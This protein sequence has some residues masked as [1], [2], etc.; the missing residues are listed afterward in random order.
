MGHLP[1]S[2]TFGTRSVRGKP[3]FPP[4]Q[5][6]NPH[7]IALPAP[8][9]KGKIG[10]VIQARTIGS[11]LP[12]WAGVGF[13][14][15][16][17]I[18]ATASDFPLLKCSATGWTVED[19]LPGNTLSA[20]AATRDGY[21]WAAGL[22]GIARFDGVRFVR[23]RLGDGL[24]SLQIQH[25]L[26]DRTGRL[27]IGTE[28]GG[29][30]LREGGYFRA[31][32]K[33]NGLGGNSVRGIAEDAEGG[34][35]VAHE[36][37]LSRWTEG[38]F[39]EMPLPQQNSKRTGC[40]SVFCGAT[41]VW[42]VSNDWIGREWRNGNWQTVPALQKTGFRFQRIFQTR[43]GVLWSQLYPYGLA[44][45]EGDQWRLF[46]TESG[47]PKSYVSSVLEQSEGVFLCGTFDEGLFLF[48]D[49][50]AKPVG[51]NQ[52]PDMDGV[53]S[54]QK[55]KLGN[56]WLG[57]RTRGLQRLRKTQVQIV[58]GSDRARIARITFDSRDR[59]WLANGEELWFEKEGELAKVL[60]P[61]TVPKFPIAT[62]NRRAAGGVWISV[63]ARGLWQHDPDQND[64]PTQKLRSG[65][66][67]SSGVL[68]AEDGVGGFWY[69][70]ESGTIGRLDEKGT[71]TPVT[72]LDR[73]G[74]QKVIGLV[75]D[76]AGGLWVRIERTGIVRLNAQGKVLESLSGT[77]G[78]PVNSIRCWVGDNQGGLWIGTPAGLYLWRNSKLLVFDHRHGLPEEVMAN[79]AHDV[80]GQLWCA[81]NNWL[82]RLSKKEMDELAADNGAVVHPLVVERSSGL[83]PVPF[84]P[85]IASR[86]I[87]GP[88]G[89]MYFPR[90]WDVVSFDPTDFEQPEP[91]PRVVVEEA[92]A[93]GQRLELPGSMEKPLRIP[94]RT[95]ELVVRYTA[96]QCAGPE[97]LRFRY[98]LEGID[99]RWTEAGD[100]RLA[101]FRRLEPGNYHF[102]VTA[103]ATG[104]SWAQPGASLRFDILPAWY[105]TWLFKGVVA[106][107]F[108]SLLVAS[109]ARR[110]ARLDRERTAERDFSRQLM[111][112]QEQE[113]QRLA[114]E[115][116]DSVG[117]NLLVIKN[118]A[119]MALEQ[120]VDPGKACEQV[121]KISEMA[122]QTLREVRG[123][124]QDLRPF[125]LEELGLTKAITA[126]A[127]RLQESSNIQIQT[128]VAMIDGQLGKEREIHFY[129]IMQELLTNVLKHS[130]ATVAGI[131]IARDDA[132]LRAIVED[133][134]QGFEPS[135]AHQQSGF[136][137]RGIRQRVRTLGG[138]IQFDS[139]AGV[140]TT[141]KLQVPVENPQI[142]TNGS[143]N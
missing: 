82:F 68:M 53:L 126:M 17:L 97:T 21:L 91:A 83:T 62:L 64:R 121:S 65:K 52:A 42:S 115:L 50:R 24:T 49:G 143:P 45:L 138:D 58:P 16:N 39:V 77:N 33:T 28:D 2:A 40:A 129:R 141:V 30:I 137:L 56:L 84:A 4:A 46:E 95:G 128:E 88:G 127:R 63:P 134:G 34:I 139:P 112:S 22:N 20:V 130:K 76:S 75:A 108:A 113:R 125:Q 111:E 27:W 99:K 104:G 47:L 100:Q 131:T 31:F 23:F 89:R 85:G 38:R 96:L 8:H 14:L 78:L 29:V 116:H 73:P 133:N 48:Q 142:K 86:A 119:L 124:A 79:L 55:D 13:V 61:A 81:A 25:L 51:L 69:G 19:G 1:D 57:T 67:E 12:V 117:Q 120:A 70:T 26:E 32:A 94:P 41:S 102:Q 66:G 123:M 9:P 59:L 135:L 90:V 6:E 110:M 72:Q 36:A 15:I 44:K 11:R 105:Q 10:A 109:Y 132:V 107:G 37:G 74:N 93:D 7:F 5:S 118:R 71:I 87:R 101:S 106:A 92:F 60:P 18:R 98:R 136:G 43:D 3:A 54:L 80:S 140:G 103:A 35:W 122:S 114:A